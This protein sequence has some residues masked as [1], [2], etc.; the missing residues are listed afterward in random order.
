[1]RHC[2]ALR[3]AAS[4]AAATLCAPP[5]ADLPLPSLRRWEYNADGSLSGRVYGKKGFREGEN[6]NTSV[7]PP[8]N[9][10]DGY[11]ITGSGSIYRLGER[12][13]KGLEEKPKRVMR[14]RVVEEAQAE[15]GE[16]LWAGARYGNVRGAA[17]VARQRM[18]GEPA[19]AEANGG[20]GKGG[21]GGA[22][23]ERRDRK[24]PAAGG[25]AAAAAD[26]A[27]AKKPKQPNQYTKLHAA[28]AKATPPKPGG[29]KAGGGDRPK[30]ANQH[31]K[32]L[33]QRQHSA[34]AA[35][36]GGG[37][38]GGGDKPKHPNQYTYLKGGGGGGGGGSAKRDRDRPKSAGAPAGRKASSSA[39]D[40]ADGGGG[41]GGTGFMGI[42]RNGIKWSARF[43]RDGQEQHIGSYAS[44]RAAAE[45][46][47]QARLQR[48]GSG[49]MEV[50]LQSCRRPSGGWKLD[51]RD[52]E[53]EAAAAAAA[54]AAAQ[55]SPGPSPRKAGGPLSPDAVPASNGHYTPSGERF[56]PIR[57]SKNSSGYQVKGKYRAI[58][59]N[60]AHFCA[61]P[62]NSAQLF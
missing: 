40:G 9:R 11:V 36:G 55:P 62:R 32:A 49:I 1:M 29:G 53:R 33:A 34:G 46:L 22:D 24:R 60:S 2:H 17:A 16:E 44:A 25:G 39:A 61:I 59:R 41:G 58:L 23:D 27:A 5:R 31:T 56:S 42:S 43:T 20:G 48:D 47:A 6:M 12:L 51:K 4:A 54:A 19:A 14:D 8:E 13:V 28:A 57:S 38:G 30:H 18:S 50:D 3:A 45:A 26:D 7:V 35:G 37:G 21:G 15:G 52:A 10:F